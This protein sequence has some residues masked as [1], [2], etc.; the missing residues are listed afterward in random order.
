MAQI[1]GNY[2]VDT[3]NVEQDITVVPAGEYPAVISDS[4]YVPTKGGKGM[5]LK[6]TWTILDGD[7]KGRKVFENL[8]LEN[9]N[10]QAVQISKATLNSI[11]LAC[12]L[13]SFQD[14]AQLHGRP[15]LIK[16]KVK[17]ADGQYDAQN[18]I[19]KHLPMSGGA[20]S[21]SNGAAPN[22]QAQ[23]PAGDGSAVPTKKRQW[24]M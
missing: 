1:G 8:N 4:D 14:S 15:V 11:M 5:M 10:T 20:P 24:E 22:F 12:G 7:C 6:L 16:V 3:Q 21:Q 18:K 17:P 13:N 23:S 2:T 19:T 9:E